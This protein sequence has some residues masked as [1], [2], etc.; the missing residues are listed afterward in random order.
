MVR[1]RKLGEQLIMKYLDGNLRDERGN[2]THPGYS[3]Q[4]R[5]RIAQDCG[6]HCK[7]G[8]LRGEPPPDEP[9]A[10]EPSKLPKPPAPPAPPRAP[11]GPAPR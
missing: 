5:R 4:W 6:N 11:A 8:R 2:V 9:K 7:V 3:E 1:W 10:P